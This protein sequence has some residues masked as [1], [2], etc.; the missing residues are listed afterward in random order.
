MARIYADNVVFLLRPGEAARRRVERMPD[1]RALP[2]GE[3]VAACR[4]TA[5]GANAP[6]G[7]SHTVAPRPAVNGE[8]RQQAGA[9]S[10]RAPLRWVLLLAVACVLPVAVGTWRAVARQATLQHVATA[11]GEQRMLPL[12][13]GGTALLDT[14]TAVSMSAGERHELGLERGRAQFDLASAVS[15]AFTVHAGDGVIGA[16]GGRFQVSRLG[17]EVRVVALAGTVSVSLPA[18]SE[19][20][21]LRPGEQVDYGY[22]RLGGVQPADLAAARGWPRGELVFHH[23]SLAEL[24]AAMNRYSDI[25]LSFG[26]DALRNLPINGVFDAGD[27]AALAQALQRSRLLRAVQVSPYEIVLQRAAR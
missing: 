21:T 1:P 18:S 7:Y 5:T 13:D 25:R 24:V 12:P 15:Q 6:L 20:V 27:P 11:T 19:Q 22:G 3:T 8:I 26:D 17:G 10:R 2:A 16:A 23:R 14:E 4:R 9:G